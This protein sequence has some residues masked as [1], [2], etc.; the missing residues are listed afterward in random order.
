M[1]NEELI[2]AGQAA[3]NR[4]LP[5]YAKRLI[6]DLVVALDRQARYAEGTRV[7]AAKEIDEIR[8]LL[9]DGPADADTF[10]SLP[11]T[12]VGDDETE[13]RPIGTGVTVEYRAPG[14]TP[15]EGFEVSLKDGR[16]HVRGIARMAV[17]PQGPHSFWIEAR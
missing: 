8:A 7:R 6:G 16:L 5:A 17:V 9:T 13:D 3:Q 11:R 1:T 10:A 15:G 2:D 12:M 4:N 14:L